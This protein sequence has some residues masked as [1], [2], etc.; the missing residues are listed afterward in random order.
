MTSTLRV[1]PVAAPIR[2]Q[3]VDNLRLAIVNGHF[4]PG[5]RLIERELVDLT[6]ASRTSVREALRELTAEG[7]VTSIPNRG[8]VVTQ[9]STTE[10]KELY[11][12]RSA[13]EGLAGRLF[14][15]NASEEQ[16][17]MLRDAFAEIEAA[18]D[19]GESILGP[20]DKFYEI[21]FVGG[22]NRS[23]HSIARTL[24]ARVSL[25]RFMSLSIPGRSKESIEELREI[26]A[27]IDAG[28]ADRA[29]AAC[30][31]HVTMAGAAGL[32]ALENESAAESD[33]GGS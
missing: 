26:V 28:D 17:Q 9:V 12:V 20:K 8:T 6:G 22:G 14:V 33:G 21:L 11:L 24:H 31:H 7:L 16:R 5:Q 3:V 23:L 19:R 13:L 18:A 4:R 29:A 30:S 15:E 1:A 32:T 10:A 2:T 25:M 27:A